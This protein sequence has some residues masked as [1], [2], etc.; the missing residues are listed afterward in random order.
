MR[1]A[2]ILEAVRVPF[3]KRGRA[4]RQSRPDSLLAHTLCGL[5]DRAGL[6]PARLDDVITGCVTQA[7]EQG[8]NIGRLA[9]LL[10]GFPVSVPATTLDRMCGSGQQAVHFAA[11]AIAAGDMDYVIGSGVESMTPTCCLGM[12]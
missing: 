3:G 11:Q 12:S 6:D 10:A 9:V 8:A 2:V 4:Y 1:E 5:T 7:G